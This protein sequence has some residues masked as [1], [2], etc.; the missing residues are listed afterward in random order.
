MAG[1]FKRLF[2]NCLLLQLLFEN[3]K[4]FQSLPGNFEVIIRSQYVLTPL[5][6]R[7]RV[8]KKKNINLLVKKNHELDQRV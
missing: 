5:F 1:E 6:C 7:E 8:N 2:E 4:F 3:L